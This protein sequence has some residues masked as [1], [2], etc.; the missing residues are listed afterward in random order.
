MRSDRS[1]LIQVVNKI[2]GTQEKQGVDRDDPF[3]GPLL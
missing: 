1:S 2:V 3:M